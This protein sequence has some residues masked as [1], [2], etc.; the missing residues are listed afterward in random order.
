MHSI[1]YNLKVACAGKKKKKKP[2][3]LKIRI[4]LIKEIGV[5][6]L[7]KSSIA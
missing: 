7:N 3:A 1:D 5:Q 4:L 2:M 6:G